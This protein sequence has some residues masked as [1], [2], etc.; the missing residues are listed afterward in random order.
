[1]NPNSNYYL[2]INTGF[3]NAYDKANDRRGAFLMIH[4]DCSSRGCYA[5]TDEQIGE[6]Y[7]LARESFLGGQK[8]VPDPGLSVP[9][10]AGEFGA[11]PHQ[12]E[13][14]LLEDD[15]GRQRPFRGDASGTQGRRLRTATYTYDDEGHLHVPPLQPG[16]LP[17]VLS[18]GPSTVAS[19]TG[20]TGN[21]GSSSSSSA[22]FG[23]LFGSKANAAPSQGQVASAAPAHA[24]LF[25][26]L[27]SSTHDTADT[28]SDATAPDTQPPA[29]VKPKT[30]AHNVSVHPKQSPATDEADASKAKAAPTPAS[31]A[32]QKEANIVAPSANN[33]GTIKGARIARGSA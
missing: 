22:F 7:S 24:G 6:I 18:S 4:G 31:S 2:A 14:G 25:G 5:M 1:M 10:D 11:A 19:T 9:H 27:F 12:S 21:S 30:V 23:N 20:S 33:N 26:S 32:P 28:S 13:H 3:P 15:Q 29:P 17:P 16:R 8:V